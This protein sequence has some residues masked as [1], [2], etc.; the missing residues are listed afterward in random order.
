VWD[1]AIAHLKAA[2]YLTTLPKNTH[3]I[4]NLGTGKG[5][6]VK[7]FVEAFEKAYGKSIKTKPYA[8]RPGD[9]AGVYASNK[10]AFDKLS[11]KANRSISSAIKDVLIW[12]NI[13]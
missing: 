5:T 4:I 7:E 3:D 11:W 8:A 12:E 6:T 2:N 1:I 13:I 9:V 10:K